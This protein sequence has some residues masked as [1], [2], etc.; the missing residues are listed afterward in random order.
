MCYINITRAVLRGNLLRLEDSTL[1]LVDSFDST[2]Q[3]DHTQQR[4][5]PHEHPDLHPEIPSSAIPP[6]KLFPTQ[7]HP[8]D[9]PPHRPTRNHPR[10]PPVVPLFHFLVCP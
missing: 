5:N 9:I 4:P 6:I 1:S 10:R 3:S 2:H 7:H 8:T